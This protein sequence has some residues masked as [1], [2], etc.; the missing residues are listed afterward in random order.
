M[1]AA[2]GPSLFHA[3]PL[4]ALAICAAGMVVRALASRETHTAR[5][6]VRRARRVFG[7]GRVLTAGVVL[8]LVGHL[9]GLLFPHAILAWN[10][11]PGRLYL[12]EGAGFGVGL[13]TLAA[14]LRA[15]SRQLRPTYA[16]AAVEVAES[17]FLAMMFLAI[18]SGLGTAAVHRW[19]SSWG[20]ATLRPYA[21]SILAG[22]PRNTLVDG[23]P[24]LIRLHLF[25]TFAALAVFP[26]TRLALLPIL[27]GGRAVAVC[28]RP[29]A[30]VARAGSMAL[31]DRCRALLWNE[32]QY[33]WL[34]KPATAAEEALAAARASWGN[35]PLHP[36]LANALVG[37]GAVFPSANEGSVR[38]ARR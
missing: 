1:N 38:K 27:L 7:G 31:G 35:R 2:N 30:R 20:I 9:A 28:T 22:D 34:I 33:R 13:V 6:A 24:F 10:R 23:L 17:V 26:L 5:L 21:L 19:G 25:A 11:A 37:E 36:H 18:A 15:V 29:I 12:L 16:P 32:P 3:W 14:W 8:L 4:V